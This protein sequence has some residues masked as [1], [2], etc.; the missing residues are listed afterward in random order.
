MKINMDTAA[1]LGMWRRLRG[2]GPGRGDTGEGAVT[3]DGIEPGEALQGEMDMWYA[4]LLR[5]APEWML[6]VA[7]LSGAA[8]PR[9]D[10]REGVLRVKVPSIAVR[11]LRV[12]LESWTEAVESVARPGD[13]AALMHLH[14]FAMATVHDPVA[15]DC[16]DGTMA[17]CPGRP[18]DRVEILDCVTQVGG[19]YRMDTAALATIEPLASF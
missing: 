14:P 18:G 16:G 11:V 1:M 5:E 15:I 7:D 9:P 8:T 12:K 4:R 2:Y 3:Y 17:L 10:G 19:E 13:E 6:D